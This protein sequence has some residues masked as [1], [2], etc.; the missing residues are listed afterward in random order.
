MDIMRQIVTPY[1][2]QAAAVALSTPASPPG[3]VPQSNFTA[4]ATTNATGHSASPTHC[5][6]SGWLDANIVALFVAQPANYD[7]TSFGTRQAFQALATHVPTLYP[8]L[9]P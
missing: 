7:V 2:N 4:L 9:G 6:T 3:A 8:Y 1:A 5:W